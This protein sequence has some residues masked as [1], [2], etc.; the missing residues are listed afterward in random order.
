[1]EPISKRR[2]TITGS[3]PAGVEHR[4]VDQ[5]SRR[6]DT[7]C[8]G[9]LVFDVKQVSTVLGTYRNIRRSNDGSLFSIASDT[10]LASLRKRDNELLELFRTENVDVELSVEVKHRPKTQ[11]IKQ[12]ATAILYGDRNLTSDI[13]ETLGLLELFLQDPIDA[14]R[15]VTYLNPQKL[16]NCP[17]A[18]TSLLWAS[19][20]IT[21]S[22]VTPVDILS[23][24]TSPDSI[25]ETEGSQYLLTPLQSHQKQALTFMVRREQ[26]WKLS[27]DATDVWSFYRDINENLKYLNTIDRSLHDQPPPVFRGGIIADTM[28]S[29]KFLSMISLIAHDRPP[30]NID[31]NHYQSDPTRTT[32][33]VAPASVLSHW[34]IEF[35]KH[36]R[37]GAM[38]WRCHHGATKILDPAELENLD[39]VLTTYPTL[40]AEW[41]MKKKSNEAHYIKSTSAITTQSAYAISANCRWAVTGTPIQNR[42]LELQSLLQFIRIY[43]YLDKEVFYEHIV[44]PW[45]DG[46]ETEAINRLKKLLNFIMLR[47]VTNHIVLPKREDSRYQLNFNAEERETYT[48]AKD[49]AIQCIEDFLQPGQLHGG[50][51]NALRKI[52][53]LRQICNFGR[54]QQTEEAEDEKFEDIT[55]APWD[56]DTASLAVRQFPS[57][58]LSTICSGCGLFLD[59]GSIFP[60]RTIHAYL[61]KCLRLLCGECYGS[62]AS[63][64]ERPVLCSCKTICPVSKVNLGDP[65]TPTNTNILYGGHDRRFPTKIRAL[66]DDLRKVPPDTQSIV[67]SFWKTTLEVAATALEYEGITYA[68]IDGDVNSKKRVKIFED[69][70][71]QT[72]RVLLIT[73]SCGAVGLNLTSASRAYLME[74]QWNPAIEEQALA[75]IYRI[76]Q[77]K[78]VT[79]VRF[80]IKDSIEKYVLD[81]Q[82][83]KKDLVTALLSP[84]A[85]SSGMSRQRLREL[86]DHLR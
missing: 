69:F 58:G 13:K 34:K 49:M 6:K 81:V 48:A 67:F 78:A 33:L 55:K 4:D 36:V 80:T 35:S 44:H 56:E 3:I 31:V 9:M 19:Q 47:R 66:V 79:T 63:Q 15:D 26:G 84:Q 61:S 28:G 2:K 24:F 43:P 76:G 37:T 64:V 60:D 32:L 17:R 1:M 77:T 41:R 59:S 12:Q 18:R 71:K 52:E 54:S 68:R 51:R 21:K 16:F 11:S 46:R 40:A 85:S 39:V 45:E 20:E 73:L 74:P 14:A 8:F 22:K 65:T 57:L 42:L 27:E 70:S 25:G 83:T 53:V 82:D 62:Y 5:A 7:I 50:Y 72:Y 10:P 30:R 38:S 86:R 23:E 75:R 29:G